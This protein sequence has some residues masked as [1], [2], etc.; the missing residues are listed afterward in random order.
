MFY[1]IE[2][3]FT[4]ECKKN[5]T[6]NLE[7]KQIRQRYQGIKILWP[8]IKP[9]YLVGTNEKNNVFGKIN[10]DLLSFSRL[11]LP[12]EHQKGLNFAH[13]IHFYYYSLVLH[14]AKQELGSIQWSHKRRSKATLTLTEL[15]AFGFE[16][17]W[18]SLTRILKKSE[19]SDI[20]LYQ[21]CK[22]KK[23][24]ILWY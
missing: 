2:Y 16:H 18:I 8:Y 21:N 7:Q 17:G 23:V 1:N 9:C 3:L 14:A 22:S 19:F 13:G 11:F 4:K 5:C 24:Y 12:I 6:N 15:E 20:F 10:L